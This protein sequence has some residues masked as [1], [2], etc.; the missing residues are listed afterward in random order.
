MITEEWSPPGERACRPM[1]TAVLKGKFISCS[2][3]WCKYKHGVEALKERISEAD[4]EDFVCKQWEADRF[5]YEACVFRIRIQTRPV[6]TSRSSSGTNGIRGST[7]LT[8]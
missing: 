4:T 3:G 7:K 2:D 8:S 6:S 5:D 1:R